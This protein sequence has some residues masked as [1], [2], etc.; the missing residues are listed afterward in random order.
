MAASRSALVGPW[1]DAPLAPSDRSAGSAGCGSPTGLPSSSTSCTS[2]PE[3]SAPAAE[4]RVW[5][6]SGA[7]KLWPTSDEPTTSPSR[8]MSEPSALSANRAWAT[9]VMAR[10]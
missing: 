2:E 1:L 9:P 7:L 6:Y 5:K 4:G 10:G 8:S 3:A